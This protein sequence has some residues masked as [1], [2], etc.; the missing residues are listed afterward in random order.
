MKKFFATLLMLGLGACTVGSYHVEAGPLGVK[1]VFGQSVD[2]L[3]KNDCAPMIA[4]YTHGTS[5]DS[6]IHKLLYGG[7]TTVRLNRPLFAGPNSYQLTLMVDA[8]SSADGSGYI[9]SVEQSWY[10]D[11]WNSGQAVEWQV[12]QLTSPHYQGCPRA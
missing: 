6:V 4:Y 1:P 7:H 5:R 10:V 9:G 11:S 2:V 3:L 12:N 8:Y